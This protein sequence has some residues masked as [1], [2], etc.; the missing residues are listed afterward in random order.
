[1]GRAGS[2]PRKV[3][4]QA[5]R[6]QHETFDSNPCCGKGTV[7]SHA[8]NYRQ[9][10]EAL[11]LAL[12]GNI[13]LQ[14][15]VGG[16]PVVLEFPWAGGL[17]NVC[18]E[19]LRWLA[20]QAGI[21][22]DEFER[23]RPRIVVGVSYG[24]LDAPAASEVDERPEVLVGFHRERVPVGG[25]HIQ[26]FG[27]ANY[28]VGLLG[29]ASVRCAEQPVDSVKRNHERLASLKSEVLAKGDRWRSNEF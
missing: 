11:K 5:A 22:H 3:C 28:F 17:N 27:T 21:A 23:H 1:M 25:T 2:S 14:D 12:L 24:H 7:R 19:R 20:R 8:K 4:L 26:V 13:K 29:H 16:W 18:S 6:D 10:I 9:F 15:F